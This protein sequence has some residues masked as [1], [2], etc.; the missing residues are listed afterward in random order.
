MTDLNKIPFIPSPH[1]Y[2]KEKVNHPE[3]IIIH[4]MVGYYKGTISWFQNPASNVSAHYLVSEL[5]EIT[6]MVKDERQA[7]HCYG[8]NHKSI[9]IETEDKKMCKKNGTW[10]TP[11][12]WAATVDLAAHLCKKHKIPVNKILPHSEPW[13]RAMKPRYAHED[14]GPFFSMDKFR[15]DVT[16]KLKAS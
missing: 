11:A 15:A 13:I 16:K 5:G 3:Y 8:L 14:P 6:Q 10:I 12:L 9:G 1:Q 7:F 4:A 2:S